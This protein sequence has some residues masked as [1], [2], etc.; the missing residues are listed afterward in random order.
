MTGSISHK[1]NLIQQQIPENLKLIAITKQVSLEAMREAYEVGLRDFGENRLQEALVKQEQLKDLTDINWHFI[2]H[3]Q[4]N[5]AKKIIEHFDWIHSVDNLSI[6]E[7]LNKLAGE[8]NCKPKVFLQV[9]AL[10]DPNKYGWQLTDLLQDL[11]SLN[12]FQ[13]LNIQGLMT[14]LPLGLSSTE[15]LNAFQAIQQLAITIRQ[16]DYPNL[17]MHELSMG[18]SSDYLLAIQAGTTMIRLG[19]IIFGER[20]IN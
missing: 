10:P 3:I 9:K 2:G 4:K 15:T 12:Q 13:Q 19:S 20:N 6:A 16:K 11:A 14:I 8:L 1:I 5:K 17:T 7:R 18:M